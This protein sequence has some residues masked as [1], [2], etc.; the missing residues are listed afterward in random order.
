M[1]R[2]KEKRSYSEIQESE[3]N[4]LLSSATIFHSVETIAQFKHTC[5]LA[6]LPD[7][8]IGKFKQD[9]VFELAQ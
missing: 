8:D 5:E 7:G 9:N 1:Q 2:Q 4:A 3:M 6:D